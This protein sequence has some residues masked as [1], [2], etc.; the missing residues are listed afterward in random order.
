MINLSYHLSDKIKDNLKRS[1]DL[2]KII[3]TTPIKPQNELKL[4]WEA[5]IEK[6]YWAL[7]LAENP[8]S[9][10][11]IGKIASSSIPKKLNEHQK[12]V[13]SYMEALKFIRENWTAAIKKIGSK[14]VLEIYDLS[15]RPVFGSTTNYFKSKKEVVDSILKFVESG[16]DHPVLKAGLIQI[17]IIKLSP[18][19]N[20][21]GRVSRLLSHMILA[22]YGFDLRGLLVLEDYYR[23]DL[24][25]L[26][27]AI[28]SIEKY[29][30]ATFWLEYY[31]TGVVKSME[32]LLNKVR[33]NNLTDQN[34]H[35]WKVSERQRKI[36]ELLEN[37]NQ[38]ITNRSVQKMFKI[39]QITASRDLSKMVNLGL[40]LPHGKG[41][42]VYYTSY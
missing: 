5:N 42:S 16:K 9:R 35:L 1:D 25:A 13:L 3:M 40:L 36:L 17:E 28:N 23:N 7:T 32:N 11:E 30:S 34:N 4:R 18:F 27:E 20:A 39:S 15:C 22:K 37:P 26:K 21:T 38:K 24:V 12:E 33:P 2:Q 41:R 8:L 31:T 14:D 19:E 10:V 6:A 29:K